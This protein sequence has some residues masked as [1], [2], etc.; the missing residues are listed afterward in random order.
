MRRAPGACVPGAVMLL[1]ATLPATASAQLSVQVSAVAGCPGQPWFAEALQQRQLQGQVRATLKQDPSDGSFQGE[2]EARSPDGTVI[3]RRLTGP[4]CQTVADALL[5]VAEVHLTPP[6][7]P[8]PPPPPPASA[9]A[10]SRFAVA[11]GLLGTADTAVSDGPSFAGGVSAWLSARPRELRGLALSVTYGQKRLDGAVPVQLTQTRARLDLLPVQALLGPATAL[12]PALSLTGG[13]LRAEADLASSTP[14]TRPLWLA[15]LGP[16]LR[17]Q[18]GPLFADL[19]LAATLTLT[20]R[21][22]VITGLDA[23][24]ASLP[25]LGASL[26]LSVGVPL[27]P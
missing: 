20:R 4:R 1:I 27:W 5:L 6:P 12:A 11:L 24:V 13:A 2:I 16:R 15:S 19:D 23:P 22:F 14:G 10:S 8:A 21:R 9:G 25:L 7:A 17:Q 3:Q 26:S 18:V